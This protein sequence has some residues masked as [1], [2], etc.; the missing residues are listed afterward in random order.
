MYWS[1][2]DP[3]LGGAVPVELTE[4]FGAH[5]RCMRGTWAQQPRCVALVG[6]IGVA[7]HCGIYPQRPSVCRELK[8]SWEDGTPSPQCDKARIAHGL[9]P[10]TREDVAALGLSPPVDAR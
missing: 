2:T 7:A 5:R 4:A 9:A 6:D 3:A 1:E 10:L 8:M